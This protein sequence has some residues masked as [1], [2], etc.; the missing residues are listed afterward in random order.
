MFCDKLEVWDGVGGGFKRERTYAYLWLIYFV[1]WQKAA[2]DC[3]AIILQLKKNYYLKQNKHI[4]S[5]IGISTLCCSLKII[6]LG[7]YQNKQ[8]I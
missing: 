4:S 5:R 7:D 8:G 1:V 2:Q 6:K 3:K